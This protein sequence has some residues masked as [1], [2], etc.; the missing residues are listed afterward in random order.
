MSTSVR[1][2]ALAAILAGSVVGLGAQ[3]PPLERINL[4]EGFSIH[5]YTKPGACAACTCSDIP[6]S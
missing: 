4:P 5:V 1:L 6:T 2:S 3:Q